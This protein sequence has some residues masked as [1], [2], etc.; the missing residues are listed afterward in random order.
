[1]EQ[2]RPYWKVIVSLAF[3]L[4][5]TVLTIFIGIRAIGYF[6]PFV[7]AWIIAAIAHPVVSWLETKIKI[8]RKF[9]SVIMIVVVLAAVIGILYLAA[10][11]LFGEVKGLIVTFPKWYAQITDGL[12]EIGNTFSGVISILPKGLRQTVES[13]GTNMDSTA[14]RIMEQISEPT[15]D[16]A[17]RFVKSVPTFLLGALVAFLAAYF[18]IADREEVLSWAKK[19]TPKPIAKRVTMVVDG[20]KHAVGGYFKAQF[21]IMCV[22]FVILLIGFMIMGQSYSLL[23]ALLI[24]FLDFLPI[25]GTGTV[26]WPWMVY[27]VLMGDYRT[28][29][30]ML[31]LYLVAL[32]THQLLQPKLIG[33]SVGLKP[34]PTLF[35]LYIGWQIGS[36]LGVILAVPVGM[37]LINLY[38]AGAFDYIL[39]DVKILIRGIMNLRK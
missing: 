12:K 13:F 19:V 8:K 2:N 30:M 7:I 6:M 28:A 26:L 16:V 37:I 4:S 34:L 14:G 23:L 3:S 38:E 22:I 11:Y 18:F 5:A 9:G 39:D 29:I 33:D 10:S 1:M 25:F 35:F 24:A 21:K 32:L 31:V 17:G 36:L 15:V 27:K 20:L